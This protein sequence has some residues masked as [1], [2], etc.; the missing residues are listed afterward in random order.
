MISAGPS[1]SPQNACSQVWVTAGA[2]RRLYTAGFS[3]CAASCARW[4]LAWR[5]QVHFAGCGGGGGRGR[6]PFPSSLDDVI[7]KLC[8]D[9]SSH[10]TDLR[11]ASRPLLH[12]PS[13]GIAAAALAAMLPAK[14]PWGGG[15][16]I[17][18]RPTQR[19][20]NEDKPS[21]LWRDPGRAY[22]VPKRGS[23]F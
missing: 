3:L 6:G 11:V 2:A 7:Q 15:Q 12:A 1:A 10:P 13:P 17:G 4:E 22:F 16:I 9:F 21:L 18:Q 8:R 23:S 19:L 14:I 5:H 20:E